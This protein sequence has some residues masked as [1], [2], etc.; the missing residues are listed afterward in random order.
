MTAARIERLSDGGYA[1]HGRSHYQAKVYPSLNPDGEEVD[2]S[3]LD[4][5]EQYLNEQL[6]MVRDLR[7]LLKPS[8]A[9]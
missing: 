1:I 3:D 8:G 2:F 4:A 6:D 9:V 5:I 7:E